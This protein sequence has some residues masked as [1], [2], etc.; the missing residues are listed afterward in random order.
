MPLS[1]FILTR[2]LLPF[3]SSEV[4]WHLI[5]NFGRNVGSRDH[6]CPCLELTGYVRT[7]SLI[8]ATE[9]SMI[10]NKASNVDTI[11]CRYATSLMIAESHADPS[12]SRAARQNAHRRPRPSYI[13]LGDQ[14]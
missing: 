12:R 4:P 8:V 10:P 5:L 6:L 2:P 9:I 13:R 11:T 7:L 14:G 1:R 3:Q